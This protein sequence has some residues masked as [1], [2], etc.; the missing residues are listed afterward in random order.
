MV[1]GRHSWISRSYMLALSTWQVL[2]PPELHNDTLSPTKSTRT[3]A[4]HLVSS[5]PQRSVTPF[6]DDLRPSS[7]LHA[8][9]VRVLLAHAHTFTHLFTYNSAHIPMHTDDYPYISLNTYLPSQMYKYEHTCIS[10]YSV[11]SC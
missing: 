10:V 5:I 6:P 1:G 9:T 3:W 4:Q 8:I 2:G 11:V 7:G